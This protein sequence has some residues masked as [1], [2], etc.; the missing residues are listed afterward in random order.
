MQEQNNNKGF[1]VIDRRVSAEDDGA[2]EAPGST[3][4]KPAYVAQLE[5]AL[6]AK[7]EKLRELAASHENVVGDLD[8]AR[9]RIRASVA[10]EAE[11]SRRTL[12]VEFL[13]VVDNLDRA[14]EA[15]R[16]GGNTQALIDGVTMVR[17]QFTDKLRALGVVRMSSMGE[18]FDPAR[19]E[20]LATVPV[21]DPSSDGT[22]VG[23]IKEGYSIGD[24]VLRPA[25]VAVA[26]GPS[27]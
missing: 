22:V 10:K 8:S 15:A 6:A 13:D 2:Q 12:I 3:G 9:T 18:P 17:E 23:V 26:K 27:A 4:D 5:R 24:D 25:S 1:S 14:L 7:D 20:A 11:L 16:E 19:H 21:Q